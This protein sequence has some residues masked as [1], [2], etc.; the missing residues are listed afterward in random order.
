MKKKWF[1][2]I[3][4]CAVLC[5]AGLGLAGATEDKEAGA[6]KELMY[7]RTDIIENI[8]SGV[9]TYEEGKEQ[10][11]QVETGALYSRD[12]RTLKDY[13]ASDYEKVR[14][15]DIVSL[16][17]MSNI[18][19]SYTF[20]GEIEWTNEGYEGVYKERITYEIGLK[21]IK[22]EYRLTSLEIQGQE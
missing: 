15:M 7:Q 20:V 13:G 3:L 5:V 2:L 8:M 4:L 10:L 19:D 11:R 14:N 9:L 17:Q 21:E 16:E 6:V 12:L 1:R 22:D 18:Y